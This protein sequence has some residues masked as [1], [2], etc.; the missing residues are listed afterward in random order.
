V[1]SIASRTLI[2]TNGQGPLLEY[3][4]SRTRE[5]YADTESWFAEKIAGEIVTKLQEEETEF[6]L[7][8]ANQLHTSPPK[9]AYI[10]DYMGHLMVADADSNEIAYSWVMNPYLWPLGNRFGVRDSF[11]NKITGMTTLGDKLIVFT[12]TQLFEC[13]PFSPDGKLAA[14]PSSHGIGFVSHWSVQ[15]I[16]MSG[17][18]LLMGVATDG[19]YAYNGVE[20]VAVLD[21]WERVLPG[22][23]NQAKIHQSVAAVSQTKNRYYVAVP[24]AGSESNDR[25]LVFDYARKAWWVWTAPH[26]VSFMATDLDEGGQERVL[27]G[28]NDGHVQILKEGTTDDSETITGTIRSAPLSAFGEREASYIGL[29][30]SASDLGHEGA[31]TVNSYIDKKDTAVLSKSLAVDARQA[32]YGS[33]VFNT[34]SFADDRFMEKRINQPFKARGHKFQ[35]EVSGTAKWKL[36]DITLLARPLERRGK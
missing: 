24:S 36:R 25:I 7:H 32:T 29:L 1:Q 11:N 8:A 19:V 31:V 23:V 4:G 3:D 16:S 28:T 17:Q 6:T 30:A 33:G 18:S 27:F 5:L 12:A 14:R 21:D 10:C 22:G 13:G 2:F 20:P 34:A 15:R 9:G 26:G 35:V